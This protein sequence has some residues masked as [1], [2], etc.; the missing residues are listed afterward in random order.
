MED[1]SGFTN[2]FAQQALGTD[3]ALEAALRFRKRH[4]FGVPLMELSEALDVLLREEARSNVTSAVASDPGADL[5]VSELDPGE[6]YIER[7]QRPGVEKEV[8]RSGRAVTRRNGVD[9][10]SSTGDDVAAGENTRDRRCQ[11]ILVD[12]YRAG[13]R[14]LKPFICKGYFRFLSNGEDDVIGF[15]GVFGP[16]KHLHVGLSV[17]IEGAEIDLDTSHSR[18]IAVA[19]GD[20]EKGTRREYDHAFLFRVLHPKQGSGH[21]LP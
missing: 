14:Q 2:L 21:L 4:I 8:D 20:F 3:A 17:L 5:F 16:W 9:D 11:G 15:N 7:S 13:L 10:E 12:L 6:G 19:R 1:G 18:D